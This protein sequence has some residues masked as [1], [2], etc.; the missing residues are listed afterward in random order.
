[1]AQ[2]QASPELKGVR[3]EAKAGITPFREV[4]GRKEWGGRKNNSGNCKRGG[5]SV[6]RMKNPQN[7]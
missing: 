7:D 6:W 3:L 4:G 2:N 5:R 1:M